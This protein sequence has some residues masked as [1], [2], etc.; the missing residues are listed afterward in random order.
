M[1]MCFNAFHLTSETVP[2]IDC[3][4]R[5][6]DPVCRLSGRRSERRLSRGRLVRGLHGEARLRRSIFG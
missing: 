4:P 2:N 1:R 5:K 6:T 3:F